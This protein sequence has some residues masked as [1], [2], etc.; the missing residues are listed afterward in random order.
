MR[1]FGGG[2]F[3]VVFLLAISAWAAPNADEFNVKFTVKSAYTPSTGGCFMTL[4]NGNASYDVV[5]SGFK[6]CHVFYPG[7]ILSGRFHKYGKQGIEILGTDDNDKP[8][9]FWCVIQNVTYLPPR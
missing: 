8:K 9:A 2:V 7:T 5:N 4:E 1:K 3:A 6:R